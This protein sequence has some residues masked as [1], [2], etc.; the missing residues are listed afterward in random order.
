MSR[1]ESIPS[2]RNTAAALFAV[3][4]A[5]NDDERLAS[6]VLASELVAR[7]GVAVHVERG[8]ASAGVAYNRGLDATDAPYV[9]FAHQDVYL[10]PGWGARLSQAVAELDRA[11][12]SWAVAAPYGIEAGTG[13]GVG[14]VWS[15]SLGGLIGKPVAGPTPA[16]S[17]DELTIIL[18]RA[19]GLRFDPA[20][21]GFHLYGTDIVQQA[22]AAGMGAYVVPLPLIHNDGFKD[23]LRSD[24]TRSYAYMRRKWRAVLP[25]KTPVARITWHGGN[26]RIDELRRHVSV[27]KRRERAIT[28]EIDPKVYSARCGWE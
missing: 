10:P 27:R 17:F 28:T 22:R 4:V 6:H 7:D 8:A 25:I 23:R 5:C 1:C 2:V 26:L 16:Q 14:E 18:R 13:A 21:P 3:V 19:S 9:I 11:D 15:S 24:F 12:P 20:L